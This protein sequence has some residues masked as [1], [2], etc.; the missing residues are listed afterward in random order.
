MN[1]ST[2]KQ[3]IREELEKAQQTV[4]I[5]KNSAI[6]GIKQAIKKD[7]RLE[8]FVGKYLIRLEKEKLG[9]LDLSELQNLNKKV[10]EEYNRLNPQHNIS[11]SINTDIDP[12]ILDKPDSMG[13]LYRGD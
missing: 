11:P 4:N 10:W 5:Y 8:N 12:Y 3:I 9:D 2:L 7:S 13:R 1:K 6:N